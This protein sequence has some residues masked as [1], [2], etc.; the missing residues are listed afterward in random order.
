MKYLI[1][2]LTVV[3]CISSGWALAY[4]RHCDRVAKAWAADHA[5][6]K[7]IATL[8]SSADSAGIRDEM[9]KQEEDVI[10]R[11]AKWI[12]CVSEAVAA[13][14]ISEKVSCLCCGWRTA[15]FYRNGHQI[16]SVAAIHGNQLRI[17]W[18]GGGGDFP[19]DEANWKTIVTALE[20]PTE[21]NQCPEGTPGESSP[22]KPSQPPGAPHP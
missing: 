14:A 12:H 16:I 17:Y 1:L 9:K 8:I 15:H 20:I 11:D 3:I 22:S 10:V 13:T 2:A 5:E 7:R 19:V 18:E 6:A 21:A 4:Y